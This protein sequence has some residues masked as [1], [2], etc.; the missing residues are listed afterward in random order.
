M[1]KK[2]QKTVIDSINQNGPSDTLQ[3]KKL[4]IDADIFKLLCYKS[5]AVS[6]DLCIL[7]FQFFLFDQG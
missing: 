2:L 6:N 5:E 7:H 1:V 4:E 3:R